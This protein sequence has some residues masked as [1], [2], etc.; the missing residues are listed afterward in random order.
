M[1]TN[2][3]CKTNLKLQVIHSF[4]SEIHR[5]TD[6]SLSG[7]LLYAAIFKNF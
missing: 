4:Q 2:K 1:I 5:T 3:T 7:M 6:C